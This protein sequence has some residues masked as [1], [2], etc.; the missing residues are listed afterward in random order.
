MDDVGI[1]ADVG[2]RLLHEDEHVR[3]WLLDLEPG[4]ATDWHQHDCGYVFIVTRPGHARC[5]YL[6]GSAEW[7]DHPSAGMTEMRESGDPH[8][9][10][11]VGRVPYGNVV[12][13]LK[14]TTVDT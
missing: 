5:E 14:C 3:V 7:Q 11:N 9:L 10:V 8:R 4:E 13:E 6:D 2:T 12:V 1:T